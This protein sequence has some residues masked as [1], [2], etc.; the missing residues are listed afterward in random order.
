MFTDYWRGLVLN[1]PEMGNT[2]LF[3]PK[4]WWKDDIFWLL[5]RSC[6][7]PFEDWKYGLFLS[8]KVVRKMLFSDCWKALVLNFLEMKIRSFLCQKVDA[9]MIFTWSFW[10]FHDV[11]GLYKYG[12][13]CGVYWNV[14][15]G[16]YLYW[17]IRSLH[18]LTNTYTAALTT[19]QVA[20]KVL[21][22]PCLIEHIP[23]LQI[24]MTYAKKTL[25]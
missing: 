25:E 1:F 23:L 5:E 13:S 19:K 21:F 22:L 2:V 17:N 12:F 20:R 7:E 4:N 18:I 24:M 3:E 6:F 14:I 11:L 10:A 8:Q 16:R 15:L 9:K